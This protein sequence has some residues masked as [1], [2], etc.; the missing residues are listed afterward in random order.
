[1]AKK[2]SEILMEE[3]MCQ[4]LEKLKTVGMQSD[5]GSR[6]TDNV[7]KIQK[8]TDE[9]SASKSNFWQNVIAGATLVVTCVK[10]GYDFWV[11][12]KGFRLETDGTYSSQTLK[13]HLGKK[14]K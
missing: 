3:V 10:V 9:A 14:R 4:N 11:A 12:D 8:A 1:M 13:W 6:I 2:R 7:V 5:E